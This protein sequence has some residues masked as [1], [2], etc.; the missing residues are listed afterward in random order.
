MGTYEFIDHTADMAVRAYGRTLEEAFGTAATAMFD[1][2]TD[3]SRIE[4][5]EQVTFTVEAI[6][7]EGLLVAFL[8]EL[9]VLHD[10]EGWIFAEF[11]VSFV[12][13]WKL[14]TT[15]KGEKFT[16]GRHAH[17]IHVKG[18]SYHMMEIQ[19]PVGNAPASVQV[20]FDI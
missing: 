20:L 17:G 1:L 13:E 2:V 9:I 18:V 19:P 16:V 7:L 4:P 5:R 8:S 3:G 11:D 12:K 15:V 10:S 14:S 6:D